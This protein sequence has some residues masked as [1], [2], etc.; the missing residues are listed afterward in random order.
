M[1]LLMKLFRGS[2]DGHLPVDAVAYLLGCVYLIMAGYPYSRASV[3][4]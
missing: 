3:L 4:A 1:S 2:S